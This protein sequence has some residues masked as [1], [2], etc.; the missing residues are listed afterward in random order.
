MLGFLSILLFLPAVIYWI[1]LLTLEEGHG[2]R[3]YMEL[4]FKSSV[5]YL[6]VMLGAIGKALLPIGRD[7]EET[8]KDSNSSDS[9]SKGVKSIWK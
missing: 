7:L 8:L 1:C 9:F 4:W 6:G 3:L 5:Y 2:L